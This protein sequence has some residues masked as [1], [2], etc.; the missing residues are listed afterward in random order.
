M[1][2]VHD[3]AGG[4]ALGAIHGGGQFLLVHCPALEGVVETLDDLGGVGAFL[5]LAFF[6]AFL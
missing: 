6:F 5:G 3:G 4:D 1:E 2:L